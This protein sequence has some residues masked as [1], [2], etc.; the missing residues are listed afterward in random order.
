MVFSKIDDEFP[1]FPPMKY[2]SSVHP[3]FILL[4]GLTAMLAVI[5][6]L[7]GIFHNLSIDEMDSNRRTFALVFLSLVI[8]G[9]LLLMRYLMRNHYIIEGDQLTC[10]GAIMSS[11]MQISNIKSIEK[12]AYPVATQKYALN[13]QGITLEDKN[14][15]RIFVTPLES[16]KFIETLQS[17]NASIEY[18]KSKAT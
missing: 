13:F 7:I 1:I 17:M 15:K 10:Y 5:I 12:A 16:K 2:R 6:G 18:V 4:Y 3:V 9:G 8:I 14:S 11:K